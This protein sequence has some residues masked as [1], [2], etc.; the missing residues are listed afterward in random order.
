ML[1]GEDCNREG[2]GGRAERVSLWSEGKTKKFVQNEQAKGSG[3]LRTSLRGILAYRMKIYWH[4]H[5]TA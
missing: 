5:C 4:T 1:G 3:G 2:R